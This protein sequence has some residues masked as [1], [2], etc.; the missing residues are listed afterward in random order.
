MCK[1]GIFGNK[2]HSKSGK[3]NEKDQLIDA[4]TSEVDELKHKNLDLEHEVDKLHAIIE[5]MQN[6]VKNVHADAATLRVDNRRLKEKVNRL[7]AKIRALKNRNSVIDA[8]N[9]GLQDTISV[10]RMEIHGNGNKDVDID[11]FNDELTDIYDGIVG[12][13]DDTIDFSDEGE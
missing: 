2:K 11:K 1:V 7:N 5:N 10:L 3:E 6:E 8:K 4:L 12:S 9:T 13:E